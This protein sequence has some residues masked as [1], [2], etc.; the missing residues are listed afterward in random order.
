VDET[1]YEDTPEAAPLRYGNARPHAAKINQIRHS[2]AY[3]RKRELFRKEC[4]LKKAVC[5][6]CGGD[7]DYRLREPHPYSWNLDHVKPVQDHPELIMEI[8]NWA[9]SHRDC[10]IRRGTDEPALDLGVPS[11][12]W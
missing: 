9:A 5:H 11:R 12:V 8:G 6:L 10:N 2:Y 3:K 1:T 7:I 4:Q